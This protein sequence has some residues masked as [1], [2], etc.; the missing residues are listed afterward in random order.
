MLFGLLAVLFFIVCGWKVNVKAGRPGWAVIVPIYNLIV[1]C[2]IAGKPWWW[3]FLMMIPIVNI[4]IA[5]LLAFGLANSFGKGVLFGLGLLFLA[6]I[7]FPILAF[8]DAQYS[9]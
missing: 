1:Y 9:G 4:V 2:Q 7:F 3:V 8:G 6:P 5:F